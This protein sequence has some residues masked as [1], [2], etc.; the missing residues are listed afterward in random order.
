MN[1]S[2]VVNKKFCQMKTT[3]T[4]WTR[5]PLLLTAAL[6]A[7]CLL[8]AWMAVHG[9][10]YQHVPVRPAD[11]GHCLV[12]LPVYKAYITPHGAIYSVGALL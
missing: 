3:S 4:L 12:R 6:L 1:M 10:L 2:S 11:A 9:L 8:T 7:S 5:I